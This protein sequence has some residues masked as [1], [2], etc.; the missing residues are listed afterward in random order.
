MKKF[1]NALKKSEFQNKK[2]LGIVKNTFV[3]KSNDSQLIIDK[4]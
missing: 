1:Q 4:K 2:S 3:K